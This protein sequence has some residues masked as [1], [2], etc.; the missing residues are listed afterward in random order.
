MKARSRSRKNF[1]N[2]STVML[3]LV[4]F[5]PLGANAEPL[6]PG[7]AYSDARLE[8]I[9]L[10]PNGPSEPGIKTWLKAKVTALSSLWTDSSSEHVIAVKAHEPSAVKPQARAEVPS[11]VSPPTAQNL[12]APVALASEDR[13]PIDVPGLKRNKLGV[14]TYELSTSVAIPRLSVGKEEHVS[15]SQ[16]ALDTSMQKVL[17]SRIIRA[18]ESPELMIPERLKQLTSLPVPRAGDVTT[19][20]NVVFL[21]KGPVS[22]SEFEHFAMKLKVEPEIHAAVVTPLTPEELRFLTGLYLYQQGDQCPTAIGLFHKLAKSDGWGPEANF[23]I[24]MC[25]KKMGL[26]T[27]F[28]ERSGQILESG[29]IYYTRKILTEIDSD[30]PYESSDKFGTALLKISTKPKIFDGLTPAVM[31]NVAYDLADFGVSSEHYHSALTWAKAVPATHPKYLKARFLLALAEYQAGSKKTAMDIQDEIVNNTQTDKENLEFQALVALNAARMDFQEHDFKKANE[32]FHKVY[33]DHPLWLQSLTELGWAQLM[34]GDFEGAIGNMYS[35][36]SPFFT[37]VYKPESYVIRTIGYL[38]LCQYGDAYKSLSILEHDY[39]PYLQQIESYIQRSEGHSAYYQT[40]RNFL[41]AAKGINEVDALAMP[42]VREMARHRDFTNLQKALNREL[43][44]RASY[45]ITDGQV[46][47]HLKSAQNAVNQTRKE[48]DGLRKKIAAIQPRKG[49]GKAALTQAQV[50]SR[51]SLQDR[52]E[53]A[54]VRLNDEFFYVDMFT[55]AKIGM[56]E[57]RR[58]VIGGADRRIAGM[59]GQIEHVL[60]NRL[61]QMKVDLARMLDNNELLR[62]EVFAGSGENIRF[63]VAGGEIGKRIPAS[64]LPKSKSLHWDFDGEFWEDEIGNYRSSLKNNCPNRPERAQASLD[65]G[66]K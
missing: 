37:S 7:G 34:D 49:A 24:A 15:S 46:E 59:R 55:E 40:I 5:S 51:K 44:E 10:A 31:A 26:K 54:M 60:A 19:I 45:S 35:V 33:K 22:R 17:D 52:L 2:A 18:L 58:E 16:Y 65:G 12:S 13:G 4:L 56:D 14:A 42:V 48:M 63:Q 30:V 23:Y 41:S 1:L 47:G 66:V 25:S 8:K 27:D 21:P 61:L 64:V 6:N 9:K 3:A 20:K 29:D 36:Q 39:R 43:D 11:P 32:N 53:Q 50:K 62:Y 28:Y 57:Y 38:N